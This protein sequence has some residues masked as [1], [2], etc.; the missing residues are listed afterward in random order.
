MSAIEQMMVRE[1]G[2]LAAMLAIAAAATLFGAVIWYKLRALRVREM[3]IALKHVLL[4]RGLPTAE[5]NS[6]IEATGKGS[7]WQ[8]CRTPRENHESFARAAT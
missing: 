2:T 7:R 6:I 1:P 4:E 8:S 3:E 5:I